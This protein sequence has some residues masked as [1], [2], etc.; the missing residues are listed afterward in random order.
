MEDELSATGEGARP[1]GPADAWLLDEP[2]PHRPASTTPEAGAPRPDW[3]PAQGV[4]PAASATLGTRPSNRRPGRPAFIAAG[5]VSA[6]IAFG[7]FL[8]LR[9]SDDGT[10]PVRSRPGT[11]AVPPAATADPGRDAK[12]KAEAKRRR[13]NARARA[14]AKARA[15]RRAEAKK[16]ARARR[17]VAAIPV[18]AVAVAPASPVVT[19]A[20]V[21]HA[22]AP[23]VTAVPAP[24]RTAAP[25][26]TA[27]PTQAPPSQDPKGRQP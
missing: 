24:A 4:Q 14:K 21:T 15:R 23:V 8:A 18:P 16:R 12:Q 25:Q 9:G 11:A 7:A 2:T 26:A 1:S 20:P 3:A 17:A 27:A 6:L 19:S 13:E 22:P 10:R 5:L